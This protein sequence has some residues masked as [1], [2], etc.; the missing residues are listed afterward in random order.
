M[1]TML[2]LTNHGVT[3]IMSRILL[4]VDFN[5]QTTHDS[6]NAGWVESYVL[7]DYNG[8]S[9]ELVDTNDYCTVLNSNFTGNY[10]ILII[11]GAVI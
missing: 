8:L 6:A 5:D 3:I 11:I 4:D 1:L 2:N 10:L 9:Y 7:N